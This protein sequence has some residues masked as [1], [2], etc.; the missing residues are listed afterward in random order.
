MYCREQGVEK[1]IVFVSITDDS[2]IVTTLAC[3]QKTS[4]PLFV[5]AGFSASAN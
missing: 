4:I 2:D 5:F 3:A 1:E